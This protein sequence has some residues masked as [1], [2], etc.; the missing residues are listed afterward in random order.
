MRKIPLFLRE[1]PPLGA[2]RPRRDS[3]TTRVPEHFRGSRAAMAIAASSVRGPPIA[4][5]LMKQT[6]DSWIRRDRGGAPGSRTDAERTRCRDAAMRRSG[7]IGPDVRRPNSEASN[8]IKSDCKRCSTAK[9]NEKPS[10]RTHDDRDPSLL[11]QDSSMRRP[12]RARQS[13]RRRLVLFDFGRRRRRAAYRCYEQC[14]RMRGI[15]RHRRS[16]TEGAVAQDTGGE[17]SAASIRQAAHRETHYIDMT[18]RSA[19]A[20]A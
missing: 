12:H 11:P 1:N 15:R 14:G 20:A 17:E 16:Q 7:Q 4:C 2:C 19:R 5:L 3:D 18:R 6:S 10:R 13:G 8:G 9:R